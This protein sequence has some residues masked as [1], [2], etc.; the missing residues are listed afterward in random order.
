MYKK[1]ILT[2]SIVALFASCSD[3][4]K[5]TKKTVMAYTAVEK[6]EQPITNNKEGYTL[7]KNN[8][9]ACHNPNTASHDAIIAPPFKMVKMHYK[10]EYTTKKEFVNAIVKWVQSPT[11]DKALMF[12]AVKRFKVMPKMDLS[13]KDLEK[14]AS[15]LYDNDVESPK[16]MKQHMKEKH[17]NGKG[18][19]KK[20]NKKGCDHKDGKSCSGSCGG[21]KGC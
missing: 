21:K 12:G 17:G 9:Y 10:R 3:S 7:M 19:M 6:V 20:M 2:I 11:E 13:T 18:M 16:W 1:I 5:E 14:I 4:K 15:F 8:C